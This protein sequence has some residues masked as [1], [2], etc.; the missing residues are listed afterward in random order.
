M[1]ERRR[2][3]TG[4]PPGPGRS[5]N[6]AVGNGENGYSN[7]VAEDLFR[8]LLHLEVQKAVRLQYCFSVVCLAPDLPEGAPPPSLAGRIAEVTLRQLRGTD[9]ATTFSDGRVVGLLLIDADA[10]SLRRILDRAT[11]AARLAAAPSPGA[12]P[13][14][15]SAGASSYP[16]TATSSRELLRQAIELLTRAQAEGG[17]RFYLPS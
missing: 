8:L 4:Q 3:G 7:L 15:L 16:E 1:T 12:A 11:E 10:G 13:L 6:R 2:N 14:S 5:G 9:V 17:N